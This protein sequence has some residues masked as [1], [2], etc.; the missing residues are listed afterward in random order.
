MCGRT[1]CKD[2]SAKRIIDS[3]TNKNFVPVNEDQSLD[4]SII[5]SADGV[6]T[7]ICEFCEV[8]LDNPQIDEFYE[9]G[10]GWRKRETDI[11]EKKLNWYEETC[12]D[13]ERH[14]KEETESL[15]MA[16]IDY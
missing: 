16:E 2:C 8:K 1:C 7:R 9:L 12:E 14:I 6:I 13:I 4:S 5:Q 11:L 3:S 15:L 10:K